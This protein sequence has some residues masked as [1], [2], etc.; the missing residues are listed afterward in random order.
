[1]AEA[2]K[3]NWK[4][5]DKRFVAFLDILGFKDSVMRNSHEDIYSKLTSINKIKK[6]IENSNNNVSLAEY[7]FDSEVYIV[8]FSD[9]IVIFSKNDD[10]YN[11]EYFLVTVRYLFGKCIGNGIPIK[12]G[13]AYG[14]VS[15]NKSEQIYF[16]Q[17][18]IDAYLLEEDLNHFGIVLHNSVDKYILENNKDLLSLKYFEKSLF[19][20]KVPLKYGKIH[21]SNINW[22]KLLIETTD[23]DDFDLKKNEILN[24]LNAFYVT[25]SGS[26]RKYVDNSIDLFE[27]LIN[28]SI[29]NLDKK[30]IT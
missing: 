20:Y 15:V 23:S 8:N 28:K 25:C 17:P 5:T 11:F 16:G 1:M 7:Y 13:I 26:P 14:D 18:I 10:L 24:K 9:S 6:T 30:S 21:H 3:T 2:K 22:F 27:E 19:N 4:T 29:I 12:G